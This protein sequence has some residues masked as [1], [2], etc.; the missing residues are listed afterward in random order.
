MTAKCPKC[1]H[2]PHRLLPLAPGVAACDR[3]GLRFRVAFDLVVA[4]MWRVRAWR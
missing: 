1:I 2:L 4:W 3:C